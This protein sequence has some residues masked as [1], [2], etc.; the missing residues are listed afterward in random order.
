MLQ[1]SGRHT[2]SNART[3]FVMAHLYVACCFVWA[4]IHLLK[5]KLTCQARWVQKCSKC[6]NTVYPTMAKILFYGFLIRLIFES[7]IRLCLAVFVS[8]AD[9]SWEGD[10]QA[11][12]YDNVFT[13]FMTALVIG[14]PLLVGSFYVCHYKSMTDPEF[15]TQFGDVYEGLAYDESRERR[16]IVIFYPVWFLLRRLIFSL[17][18]VAFDENNWF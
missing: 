3:I 12:L 5:D 15:K 14:L 16:L 6:L 2:V 9:I 11:L 4:L 7:Y 1:Y 13:V 17:L 10:S 18:V 8:L